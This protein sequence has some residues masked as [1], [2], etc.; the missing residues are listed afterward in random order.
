MTKST[1]LKE[2]YLLYLQNMVCDNEYSGQ[3]YQK[4]F[5]QLYETEFYAV[6]DMDENRIVDAIEFRA[7]YEQSKTGCRGAIDD[8]ISVL[9]VMVALAVRCEDHIMCNFEYGNRTPKWFWYMI[10]S[11]GLLD[12]DDFNYIPEEID[13]ILRKM[14]ERDYDFDGFGGLFYIENSIHDLRK[15][16][17]WY[18]MNWWLSTIDE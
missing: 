14:L 12:Y 7:E 2:K 3:N 6:I 11:M 18:Q 9:E 5:R 15:A 8:E 4:L 13:D 10:Q 17:I 16:D 1:N